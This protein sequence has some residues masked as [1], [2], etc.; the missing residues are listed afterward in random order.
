MKRTHTLSLR[1]VRRCDL[2]LS[3]ALLL[4]L[5]CGGTTRAQTVTDALPAPTPS[6]SPVQSQDSKP[7]E[8]NSFLIE[9]AYNQEP[10]VVQH[11]NTFRL[12]R[13]SFEYTFTQ[14][15]PLGSR[16]HQFSYTLP[17][18][19]A[20]DPAGGRGFGDIE[21]NYRYQ[22]VDRESVAVAPRATLVLPTGKE[23]DELSKGG[24]GFEFNLPVSTKLGRYFVTHSNIGATFTPRAR[25]TTG[26]RAS[27]QDFFAGQSLVWLLHPK[28]NLLVEGLYEDEEQVVGLNQTTRDHSFTI[29]PGA[30]VAIDLP[31]N[32]QIVPGVSV[33]VG[34]GPSRDERAVFFYLSFEH[35]FRRGTK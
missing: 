23:E 19:R 35:P 6:P 7:I 32:F 29:N 5:L 27:T 11:V 13:D 9:E 3:F 8:D 30:R 20:S 4:L 1:S 33:P 12:N 16:R 14:E 2:L 31:G 26:E 28:F 34:L 25:S 24:F 10:G 21:L 18:F 22:L 17:L 15:F